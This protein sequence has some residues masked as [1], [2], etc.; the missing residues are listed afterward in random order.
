MV[1]WSTFFALDLPKAFREMNAIIYSLFIRSMQR[2]L[3]VSGLCI[4]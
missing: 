4:F 2:H 3:P 1:Q